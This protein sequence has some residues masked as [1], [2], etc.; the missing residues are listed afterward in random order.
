MGVRLLI[1]FVNALKMFNLQVAAPNWNLCCFVCYTSIYLLY[2]I[3]RWNL[4]MYNDLAQISHKMYIY[5]LTLTSSSNFMIF[6]ILASGSSWVLKSFYKQAC[7]N[8]SL[9]YSIV[10]MI[11]LVIICMLCI[12]GPM[13]NTLF[14]KRRKTLLYIQIYC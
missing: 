1:D 7:I 2:F 9:Q 14:K 8:K 5:Q 11:I 12:R 3:V 6:F 4:I 13:E 10:V